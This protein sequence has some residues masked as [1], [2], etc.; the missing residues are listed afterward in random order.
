MKVGI[1]GLHGKGNGHPFSF[2]AII[3]GYSEREFK[4]TRYKNILNYLKKKKSKEFGIKNVSVTH[5]W[6]QNYNLTKTLCKAS[7][8]KNPVKKYTDMIGSIDALIIARDD[9]H[10]KISLPF[11]KKNI[12]VFVDKPL[13]FKKDELNKFKYY[14]SR[15]KL[16]STSGLRY[17]KEIEIL[18]KKIKKIGNIKFIIANVVN[19]MSKYGVHMLD[20]IDELGFLNVVKIQK[21]NSK[22]LSYNFIC[23]KNLNIIVNCFG[24]VEPM[25]NLTIIGSKGLET[26]NFLDNFV[27]FKNTLNNFFKMIRTK[28]AILNPNR[29][30]KIMKLIKI[31]NSIKKQKLIK[32]NV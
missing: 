12:P 13:S 2:S 26:I 30:I 16:M 5:A 4:K 19:D 22:Y 27:A 18:K 1:V 6:T 8:I 20:I 32:A 14:M 9:L 25:Y 11:L 23:K 31:V 7:K 28:K 24:K 21:I 15:A 10:L 17:S 3:N 29:T